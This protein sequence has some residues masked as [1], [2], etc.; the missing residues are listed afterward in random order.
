MVQSIQLG[1]LRSLGSAAFNE[2]NKSAMLRT[3]GT[4]TASRA[5]LRLAQMKYQYFV[6]EHWEHCKQNAI[7]SGTSFQNRSYLDN[8]STNRWNVVGF[9][10]G[11]AAAKWLM[12]IS[13]YP[14]QSCRY[15]LQIFTVALFQLY[16]NDDFNGLLQWCKGFSQCKIITAK[17]GRC[18]FPEFQIFPEYCFISSR[19][20]LYINLGDLSL[21]RLSCS[22]S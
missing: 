22:L 11:T 3:E 17:I 21:T 9:Q 12:K 15:W 18:I 16:A 14:C 5:V 8:I 4:I 10:Q 7:F 1:F 6:P 2:A 20:N 13:R 19:L